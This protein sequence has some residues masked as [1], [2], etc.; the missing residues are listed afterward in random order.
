MNVETAVITIITHA[1]VLAL[2]ALSHVV[3]NA[4]VRTKGICHPQA[5]LLIQ[6]IQ[7][8]IYIRIQV[9]YLVS[10][11]SVIIITLVETVVITICIR[12]MV[13]ALMALYHVV[14]NA[15]LRTKGIFH[16]LPM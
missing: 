1:M 12:A 9:L 10:N 13:F 14:M 7:I 6:I 11:I 3:M 15:D 5:I 16:P 2:M 4:D 8:F